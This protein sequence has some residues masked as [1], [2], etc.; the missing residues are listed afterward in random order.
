MLQ[1]Q[2]GSGVVF[3]FYQ[4]PNAGPNVGGY[5]GR[6]WP[7]GEFKGLSYDQLRSPGLR[8]CDTSSRW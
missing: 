8:R 7:G 6:V 5:L 1:L 4:P 3:A 2:V